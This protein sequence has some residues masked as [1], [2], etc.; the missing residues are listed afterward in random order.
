MWDMLLT[1]KSDIRD[2][3]E[4]NKMILGIDVYLLDE[5]KIRMF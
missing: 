1:G 4:S 2:T 5:R 3:K